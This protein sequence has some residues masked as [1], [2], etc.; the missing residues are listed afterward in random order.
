MLEHDGVA[1]H[2]VRRCEPGDLVIRVV[3]RHDAQQRADRGLAHPRRARQVRGQRLVLEER[4]P[5]VGVV[6]VD[7]RNEPQFSLGGLGDLAHLPCDDRGQFGGAVAI[8]LGHP[9]QDPGALVHRSSPPRGVAPFGSPQ[10]VTDFCVSRRRVLT[11]DL[12]GGRVH[13]LVHHRACLHTTSGPS[14]TRLNGA[15][16]DQWGPRRCA[17]VTRQHM[18]HAVSGNHWYRP[19]RNAITSPGVR[20]SDE[21]RRAATTG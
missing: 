13:Y 7:G 8:Q 16:R 19:S 6:L 12:P 17:L 4:R 21:R 20:C 15:Q 10:H 2:Q 9:A 3:P 1:D 5:V 18:Y 14:I 11:F